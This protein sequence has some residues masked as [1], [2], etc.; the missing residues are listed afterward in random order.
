MANIRRAVDG[1]L[2]QAQILEREVVSWGLGLA[3]VC[4]D[5]EQSLVRT[6]LESVAGEMPLA[7]EEDAV[8]AWAGAFGGEAGAIC[9]AGTGANCFGRNEAGESARADGLGPLL[10]DRGSGYSIGEA[11]LRA[12]CAADEGSGP[13]TS[14]LTPVLQKLEVVSVAQLVQLVYRPDFK[15]DRVASVVPIVFEHANA[16]DAVARRVLEN[17]GDAL[18]AT[19]LAVMRRLGLSRVAPVGGVLSQSSPLRERYE[20]VLH[21]EIPDI[22]IEEARYDAAIGAAL[23]L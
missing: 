16:D 22:K 21:G 19:T 10:G 15:R 4:S 11:A 12:V 3:G 1:A 13:P 6:R 7:I 2:S 20:S 14:L 5:A 8:A 23:L 18:A 9:I 17:A